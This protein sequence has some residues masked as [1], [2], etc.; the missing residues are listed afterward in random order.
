MTG[1]TVHDERDPLRVSPQELTA[2]G[3]GHT[4]KLPVHDK[5]ATIKK[6][7]LFCHSGKSAVLEHSSDNV[8]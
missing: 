6:E 8:G 3:H 4:I 2:T 1:S 7:L 5:L